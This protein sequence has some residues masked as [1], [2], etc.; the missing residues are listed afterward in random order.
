M[1]KEEKIMV[2]VHN[3]KHSLPLPLYKKYRILWR[4]YLGKFAIFFILNL[5]NTNVYYLGIT[6]IAEKKY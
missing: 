5:L 4:G 3:L 2:M 1:I 6:Q